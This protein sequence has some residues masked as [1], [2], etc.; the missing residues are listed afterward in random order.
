MLQLVC[1]TPAVAVDPGIQP[2]DEPLVTTLLLP[3][4]PVQRTFRQRSTARYAVIFII[5]M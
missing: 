2:G 3:L 5:A 1:N 4:H